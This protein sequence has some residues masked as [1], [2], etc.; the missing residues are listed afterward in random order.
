[1]SRSRRK[2]PIGGN[3]TARSD[4]SGKRQAHR[5]VRAHVRHW[6]MRGDDVPDDREVKAN[7]PWGWPKDGKTWHGADLEM[8]K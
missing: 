1:M 5:S 6:L 2:T 4:R 3:T 8:R 7:N